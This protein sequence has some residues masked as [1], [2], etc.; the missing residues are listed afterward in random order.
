MKRVLIAWERGK[1]YGHLVRDIPVAER[2]R[3]QGL[4][5]IFAVKDLRVA[6]ELLNP[7]GFSF[8]AAPYMASEVPMPHHPG[9]YAEMMLRHG[10]SDAMTLRGLITAW[11]EMIRWIRPSI[12]L[13][14]YAPTAILAA[15]ATDIPV[16]TMGSGWE[17]P[18]AIAP[19]PWLKLD[20]PADVGALIEIERDICNKINAV[21]SYLKIPPLAE[22][23]QLF[24]S[25]PALLTTFEELDQSSL[26]FQDIGFQRSSDSYV[27]YIGTDFS[28]PSIQWR[29]GKPSAP[30]IF[31][32]L[33]PDFDEAH[34]FEAVLLLAERGANVICAMPGATPEHF[35]AAKGRLELRPHGLKMA[36][37]LPEADLFVG[38]GGAG[39]VCRALLAATPVFLAPSI[40]ERQVT[41]E[42]V[43]RLGA[44][45][46]ICRSEAAEATA[47]VMT[48]VL[49]NADNKRSAERFAQKYKAVPENSGASVIAR[50]VKE[51]L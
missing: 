47:A 46:F 35:E 14:D 1:A 31:A 45:A 32:Y 16:L 6:A 29:Q 36:D 44:G 43:K 50:K 21:L 5:V 3:A 4:E 2:L 13:A 34:L 11:R 28:F 25:I 48:A 40:L 20:E 38:Y 12:I 15:R 7:A 22:L 51:R 9:N 37:I 27:G 10:Y 49:E 30:N 41:A 18:P 19:F 24:A 17:I 33:R 23:A 8:I 26:G 39:G 42:L